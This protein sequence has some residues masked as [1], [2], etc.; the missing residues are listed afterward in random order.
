MSIFSTDS[1]FYKAISFF[2][3][4][5]VLNLCWLL[6][7]L[8]IVT[9]GA[10]TTAAFYVAF[11]LIDGN[12]GYMFKSFVKAFKANWKQGTILW[13]IAAVAIYALYLDAQLLIKTEDPSYFLI[14]ASVVSFLFVFFALLYAFPLS[15]RYENKWY[16][17]IKNSFILSFRYFKKT[18]FLL[19]ILVLEI[20]LFVWNN[21]TII[22]L[23]LIGPMVCIYT[24]AG[25]SRKIFAEIDDRNKKDALMAQAKAED[26]AEMEAGK[27][28]GEYEASVKCYK[29]VKG[30]F[31]FEV[32]AE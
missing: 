26:T 9:I 7:S 20:G 10:S 1:K 6:F 4:L 19:L 21:K 13:L 15:A 25:T 2:G 3:N 5:V 31:K 8:P 24:V 17:H 12:E 30:D 32:V 16:M 11:K 18:M 29:D 27:E 28:A 14:I 23:V 22:L